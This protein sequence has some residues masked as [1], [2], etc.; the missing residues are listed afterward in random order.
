MGSSTEFAIGC[1][2]MVLHHPYQS[3]YSDRDRNSRRLR[4][5][6]QLL[7]TIPDLRGGKRA[8]LYYLWAVERVQTATAQMGGRPEEDDDEADVRESQNLSGYVGAS[9]A[10]GLPLQPFFPGA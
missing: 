6:R 5:D 3:F 8:L 4:C 7:P 1:T 9:S 2:N 10:I